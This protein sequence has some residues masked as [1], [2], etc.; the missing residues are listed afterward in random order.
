MGSVNSVVMLEFVFV[1]FVLDELR[2]SSLFNNGVLDEDSDSSLIGGNVPRRGDE[3][4]PGLV[5]GGLPMLPRPLRPP[6]TAESGGEASPT[7]P[8]SLTLW[9]ALR[10]NSETEVE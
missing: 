6:N 1:P 3:G 9:L 8:T 10:S 2:V 7:S 5:Y 4:E